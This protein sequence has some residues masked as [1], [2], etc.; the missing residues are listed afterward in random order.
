MNTEYRDP[1]MDHMSILMFACQR[2]PGNLKLTKTS[3]AALWRRG[4]LP[5]SDET[6]AWHCRGCEVGA[7][8]AGAADKPV[9]RARRCSRCGDGGIKIV[10]GIICVS[11][12]NRQAE[13]AKG[14]NGKG[15]APIAFQPLHIWADPEVERIIMAR[16]LGEAQEVWHRLHNI[17]LPVLVDFGEATQEEVL[18]WWPE[19]K[20][21]NLL[22]PRKRGLSFT[23]KQKGFT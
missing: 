11:C 15:K 14:C 10:G 7:R 18:E 1:K 3:C 12:Y 20:R 6:I 8:H 23:D 5:D 2:Q 21:L 9:P 13:F 4:L 17:E 19:V 16:T 22:R